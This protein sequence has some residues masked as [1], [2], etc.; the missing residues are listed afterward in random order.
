MFRILS[1]L[2][3]ILTTVEPHG[4]DSAVVVGAE[5]DGVIPDAKTEDR[6]GEHRLV[7]VN[8]APTTTTTTAMVNFLLG[9][10]SNGIWYLR[11]VL[12]VENYDDSRFSTHF[13][14]DLLYLEGISSNVIQINFC[15]HHFEN[16]LRIY[17]K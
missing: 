5:V 12:L 11:H 16:E 13:R 7:K 3:Q 6:G 8:L 4:Q 2:I 1:R 17:I 10:L 14:T 15:R 9:E